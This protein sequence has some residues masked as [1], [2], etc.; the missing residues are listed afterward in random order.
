M[1]C[2]LRLP[3]ELTNIF[4]DIMDILKLKIVFNAQLL[5]SIKY[6]HEIELINIT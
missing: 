6:L 2:T 3:R 4:S 5:L 1:K